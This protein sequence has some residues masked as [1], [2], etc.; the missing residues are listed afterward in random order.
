MQSLTEL[1]ADA[2][3]ADRAASEA[4]INSGA[5]PRTF[6]YPHLARLWATTP[7]SDFFVGWVAHRRI[8]PLHYT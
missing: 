3:L 5:T 6:P 4:D 1:E 8:P 7:L 2:A